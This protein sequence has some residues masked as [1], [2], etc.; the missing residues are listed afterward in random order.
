M[1]LRVAKSLV[2]RLAKTESLINALV[3][4]LV[5]AAAAPAQAATNRSASQVRAFK[6]LHPCPSTGQ[7]KGACPG[8]IVDHI[9]PRCLGGA[10][11]PRNMQW[12]TIADAKRKDVL[13]RRA[14]QQK[15]HRQK[16]HHKNN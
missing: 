4:S 7:A 16:R 10:D 3:I 1:N 15:R 5:I 13:E 6:Q 8:W 9:K 12:Q 14:C 11:R 2:I